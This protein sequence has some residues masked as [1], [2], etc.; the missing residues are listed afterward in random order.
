MPEFASAERPPKSLEE[1]IE[2]FH[3]SLETTNFAAGQKVATISSAREKSTD[4]DELKKAEA[5][6]AHKLEEGLKSKVHG[7]T[8]ELGTPI[9]GMGSNLAP[10][11]RLF[12]KAN[13]NLTNKRIEAG[14][15][16]ILEELKSQ[17]EALHLPIKN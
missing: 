8:C 1:L 14:F 15:A 3:I 4:D 10:A 11:E 13:T 5:E 6:I 16:A 12:L 2:K 7:I 17:A 9:Y